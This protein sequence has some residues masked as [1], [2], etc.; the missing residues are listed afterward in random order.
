MSTPSSGDGNEVQSATWVLSLP[1]LYARVACTFDVVG[2]KR[3]LPF[4]VHSVRIERTVQKHDGCR[5]VFPMLFKVEP[6]ATVP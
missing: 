5:D 1:G 2:I 3:P 6:Q 4:L